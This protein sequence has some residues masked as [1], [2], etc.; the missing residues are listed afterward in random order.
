MKSICSKEELKKALEAG[1]KQITV[2][3]QKLLKALAV[4]Y[5]IQN[6]K[7]KGGLLLATLSTVVA[8]GSIVTLPIMGAGLAIGE[9]NLRRSLLLVL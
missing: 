6:N 1:K 8:V 2:K 3:D 4:Q 5:W 9:A 7:V